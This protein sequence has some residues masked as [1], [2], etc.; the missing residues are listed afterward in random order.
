MLKYKKLLLITL[1]KCLAF[2]LNSFLYAQ[3]T[4]NFIEI[5]ATFNNNNFHIGKTYFFNTTHKISVDKCL[6]YISCISF[7]SND[8]LLFT[9]PQKY[10]LIN[11]ETKNKIHF[12]AQSTYNVTHISF[13]VG[14]DSL[15]N[16]LGALGGALDP[17]KGMYWT[18]QSGYINLKIEGSSSMCSTRNQQF[19]Y[20]IG[21]YQAPYNTLQS[22]RLPIGKKNNIQILFDLG[23][24]LNK[25]MASNIC[26]VM[27]PSKSS[28]QLSKYIKE[29]FSILK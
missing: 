29:S 28:V 26:N 16:M 20:H 12:Q 24:L 3:K 6:F 18:W 13:N 2:L 9:I 23:L 10:H 7:Y 21:G 4:N 27:S 19:Q 22:V 25:F 5:Y 17:T 11:F 14:V 15:T 1:F 8:S